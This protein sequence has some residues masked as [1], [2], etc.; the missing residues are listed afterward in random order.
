MEHKISILTRCS[1]RPNGFKICNQSITSQ[2]YG[3]VTHIVSYDDN[4][5]YVNYLNQYD[6]IVSVK[7]DREALIK[8]DTSVNPNTGK[9]SPHN[10]YCNNL[11]EAAE[12]GYIMFLDDDDMLAHPDVL[13]TINKTIVDED[14]ML[15]WKMRYPTGNVLPRGDIFDRP[16]LGGIGSPCFLVHTKWAKQFN[17]DAW[18]CGDFRYI[19][20][21]FNVVPNHKWINNVLIQL[22]NNGDQGKKNDITKNYDYEER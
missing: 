13:K 3:N 8:N 4:N 22:N 18:K 5:D 9:Y 7:V 21:L 15:F 17:W 19:D 11:L 10:L 1:N 6:N 12:D 20:K 16:R 2:G 14:T